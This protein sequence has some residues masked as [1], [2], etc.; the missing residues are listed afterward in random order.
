ML[1]S[2][3]CV[4][5]TAAGV[6]RAP[7]GRRLRCQAAGPQR[8]WQRAARHTASGNSDRDPYVEVTADHSSS[9]ALIFSHFFWGGFGAGH[10]GRIKSQCLVGHVMKELRADGVVSCGKACRSE[11]RCRSFNLLMEKGSGKMV[12]QLNNATRHEAADGNMKARDKCYFF[13]L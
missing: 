11:P 5:A 9:K 10:D 1:Q 3:P 13:D 2:P 8:T 6:W 12:C 4:A 7:A